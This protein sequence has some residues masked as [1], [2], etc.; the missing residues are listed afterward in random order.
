MVKL[1]I[2]KM[3]STGAEYRVQGTERV[4]SSRV[5]GEIAEFWAFFDSF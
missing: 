4:Q 2:A 1:G 3:E 5:Q